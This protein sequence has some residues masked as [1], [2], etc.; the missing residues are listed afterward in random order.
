MVSLDPC[1]KG[2]SSDS[3][4]ALFDSFEQ[5]CCEE[6]VRTIR[7]D[8][9]LVWCESIINEQTRGECKVPMGPLV[10]TLFNLFMEQPQHVVR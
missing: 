1:L 2:E 10:E 9:C 3:F 5:A 6:S 4:A 8:G 7:H